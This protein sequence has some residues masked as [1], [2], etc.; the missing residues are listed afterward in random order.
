MR[1]AL[2]ALFVV[3]IKTVAL[4]LIVEGAI[5]YATGKQNFYYVLV[6]GCAMVSAFTWK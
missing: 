1:D 4:L 6:I 5:G 2:F 3:T